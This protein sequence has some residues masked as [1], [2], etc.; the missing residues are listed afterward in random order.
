MVL[1]RPPMFWALHKKQ[2]EEIIL[3]YLFYV[4][5]LCGLGKSPNILL[6]HCLQK[7]AKT[8]V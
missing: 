3:I 1:L 6:G 2:W 8:H 5:L 4:F 7:K